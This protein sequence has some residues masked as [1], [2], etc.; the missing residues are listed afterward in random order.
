MS[1]TGTR[2]DPTALAGEDDHRYFRALE[3][4]FLQ[5][6]G[7]ATLLGPDDWQ[8]AR[9]WRR[10]GI[11]IELVV[12]VME[13]LF[14][15]QRE[16]RSKRGI[17]SLRYFRA[18]VAAAWDERLALSAGGATAPPSAPPIARRLQALAA[19]IPDGL[20][21]AAALRAAILALQGDPQ[22]VEGAL[23]QL[24]ARLLDEAA[25]SLDEAGATALEARVERALG[26][27]GAGGGSDRVALA[28][29]LRA[30]AL[31]AELR[32]PLLSLF[33]PEAL[34]PDGPAES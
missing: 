23:A 33:A 24:D 32:L 12:E 9:E 17:S 27:T 15:R 25:R 19:A 7:S 21:G 3:E 28:G 2:P 8:T 13:S 1:S 18:A 16:R 30:Q 22:S 5:L 6:R 31:R 10:L 29:R 11:P 14:A 26:R 20:T 34:A 4:A